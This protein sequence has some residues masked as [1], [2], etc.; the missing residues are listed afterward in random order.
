MKV[1]DSIGKFVVQF[2][3]EH[4]DTETDFYVRVLDV[5][6]DVNSNIF[7]LVRLGEYG[8]PEVQVFSHIADLLHKFP[9]RRWGWGYR[10]AVTN[11]KVLLATSKTVDVYKHEG[12]YVR[13]FVE[14]IL[15]CPFNITASP[16]GQVMILDVED[17]CVFIF[18]DDS[19]L[20]P[21]KMSIAALP[22]IHQMNT[23]S[24]LDGNE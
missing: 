11:N 19:T 2:H 9:V 4:N 15:K 13:S 18:T 7:V 21:K 16:D 10:L 23:L 24:S 22:V 5:A 20:T 14:G 8:I 6:T 3:P 1:F 12:R 17:S